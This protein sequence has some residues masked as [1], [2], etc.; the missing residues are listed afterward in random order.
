MD[1]RELTLGTLL[2]LVEGLD[3]DI[4]VRLAIQPAWPFEYTVG[5]PVVVDTEDGPV[6]YLPERTQ[7]GYLGGHVAAELGWDG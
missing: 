2:E 7:T 4:P 1:Q 6:V 5:E 3:H